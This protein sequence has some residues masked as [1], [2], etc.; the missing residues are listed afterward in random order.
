MERAPIQRRSRLPCSV[1][2]IQSAINY[3]VCQYLSVSVL[4]VVRLCSLCF[5]G[6]GVVTKFPSSS[7]HL[8]KRVLADEAIGVKKGALCG[9]LTSS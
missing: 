4:N 3:P 9:I 6:K 5:Q 1:I 8:L 2:T 7:P